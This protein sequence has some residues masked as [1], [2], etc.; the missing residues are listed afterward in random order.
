M[1]DFSYYFW[2]L[3][4]A[5]KKTEEKY[6]RAAFVFLILTSSKSI[7][8]PSYQRSEETK[9]ENPTTTMVVSSLVGNWLS[10]PKS[11]PKCIP[12]IS[13][14]DIN[15]TALYTSWAYLLFISNDSL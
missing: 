12:K 14:G 3:R 5:G 1:Q 2:F 4:L 15:F 7:V 6:Q 8:M 13:D 9:Y 11:T 10:N